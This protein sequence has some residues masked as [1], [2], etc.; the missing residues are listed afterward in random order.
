M[1]RA[2]FIVISQSGRS[3]DLVMGARHARKGGA[4]TI[5]IVND[6]NSPVSRECEFV[7]PIGAG[8]EIAVAA[9]KSVALTMVLCAQL[10]S[11]NSDRALTNKI[12][13]QPD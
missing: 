13:S 12:N 4:L 10:I 8:P 5:A 9:T 11:L 7:L 1:Q 2:V 3:P 6:D